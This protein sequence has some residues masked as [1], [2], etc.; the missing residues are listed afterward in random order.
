[1]TREETL[2]IMGVLKAAYPSYY[3]DM[4]RSDANGI[5]DLWTAMFADDAVEVVAAAVKAHIATDTKGFPPHIG[6][7]KDAIVKLT[8]PKELELTEQEAWSLVNKATRNG[9]WAAQEEFEKLP[10]V[11]QRLVGSPSQLK[12]WAA[13]DA[14]VVASVV[15]SNFQRSYKARISYERERL[16]LPEDIKQTMEMLGDGMA[17]KRLAEGASHV[18]VDYES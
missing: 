1:M 7:I 11:L 18:G 3:K 12:E 4:K 13:M 15:A 8:Q 9:T 16:A 14:D 10:E 2:A 6:V 5:V 17:L